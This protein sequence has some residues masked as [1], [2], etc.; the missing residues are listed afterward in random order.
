MRAQAIQTLERL[1]RKDNHASIAAAGR[2]HVVVELQLRDDVRVPLEHRQARAG[3]CVPH[4]H[5]RV[6]APSHHVAPVECDGVDLQVVAF[7]DVQA[8]ACIHVPDAACKVVASARD[9]VTRRVQAPHRMLVPSQNMHQLALLQ[10]PHT[11]RAVAR[12]RHGNGQSIQHLDTS[13]RRCVSTQHMLALPGRHIPHAQEPV[14]AGAD[15]QRVWPS[16]AARATEQRITLTGA[17]LGGIE[18]IGQ[19][20]AAA[21]ILKE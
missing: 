20:H 7:E 4:T 2:E 9:T 11:Q 3:V 14:G 6:A 15:Q 1:E 10:I 16:P 21:F 18:D 12:A 17:Q 5:R 13:D 19:R 8:P